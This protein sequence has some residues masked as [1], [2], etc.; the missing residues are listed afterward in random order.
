MRISLPPP[1]PCPECGSD[2]VYHKAEYAVHLM[3]IVTTPL[4]DLPLQF[5][6]RL[7]SK[8]TKKS[9]AFGLYERLERFGLGEFKDEPDDKTLLL[10]QVLWSEAKARG[11]LM[12]EFRFLG[13]PTNS[14]VATF[15]D[16]RRI[17]F[18]SI[19]FPPGTRQGVWWLD[20]KA[21][22]KR[23]FLKLGIPVARGG[24]AFS[25]SGAK[26][27][28]NSIDKPVIVKP[29]E[30]SGSRHTTTHISDELELERAFRVA[31]QVSPNVI[32]EEE[33]VGS[34]YRPTLVGGKL[35]ATIRR[36]R[37]HVVG[38]GV[39]AVSELIEKENEHP[40]RQGP[41]FSK[42]K[43]SPATEAEL[44][45]QHATL[46][47]IPEKNRIMYLHQKINWSVGGTTTDVTDEVHSDNK[48][49]FEEIAR[50]LH[51]PIVG[52]DFIIEDISKSWKEQEKCGVI[53]CN[54]R[55][56]FDNHHLPFEGEPRN[57]AGV[58][59]D[60]WSEAKQA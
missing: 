59:W 50:V 54:G 13:L 27:I 12:R 58:I 51:A 55:P 43:I 38:D 33:L 30:G 2:P 60:M 17:T 4:F 56:F 45:L 46:E 19:P 49:L 39:H 3:N 20:S 31:K 57:V 15:P 47:T 14:F 36:D 24:S 16:G 52:I 11:I 25:L 48:A 7:S 8:R 41:Y 22:M 53:E 32:I 21:T 29:F 9:L 10:C 40:K 42:I 26:K 37:P 44:A 23:R 1:K 18:E 5:V 6:S 28:F 34:V 35:I